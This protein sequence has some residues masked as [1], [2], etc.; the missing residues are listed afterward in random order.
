MSNTRGTGR[1]GWVV[2][3][4]ESISAHRTADEAEDAAR[5]VSEQL[6]CPVLM[7]DRTTGDA[8]HVTPDATRK[9]VTS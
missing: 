9:V 4:D 2:L 5:D 7:I 1:G 3:T 8:W 6:G